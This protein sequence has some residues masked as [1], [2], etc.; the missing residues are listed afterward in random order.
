MDTK[1]FYEQ[2]EN[3]KKAFDLVD[4]LVKDEWT[5]KEIVDYFYSLGCSVFFVHNIIKNYIETKH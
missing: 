2:K 4:S 5:T 3:R 1:C